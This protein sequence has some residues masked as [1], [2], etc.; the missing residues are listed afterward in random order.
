M[1]RA[2]R[3]R[4]LALLI[5]GWLALACVGGPAPR[6]HFYRLDLASPEAAN[7]SPLLPGT[8][9][10][11]RLGSND[12]LRS[13]G[14]VHVESASAIELTP[15]S[16]HLWA[17]SPTLMLQQEL[18]DFLRAARVA[19]QVV[20][21]QMNVR[22]DWQV[23]GQLR[24]LDHV[25]AAEPSVIVELELRLT[26]ARTA[27]LVVRETYRVERTAGGPGVEDAVR[28]LNQA[29]QSVFERF[30]ADVAAAR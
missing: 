29:V 12:L 23:T 21:P 11:D 5:P 17:D 10:V 14:V 1:R 3:D 13:R 9:E 26:D 15:Y 27:R 28:A 20:T 8:L 30:V 24:R 22:E 25:V 7:P 4:L 19:E 6:D 2:A 16:F 18:A